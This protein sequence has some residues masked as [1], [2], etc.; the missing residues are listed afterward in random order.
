MKFQFELAGKVVMVTG[1]FSGLGLHFSRTLA[2]QGCTVAMC[3]RRIELGKT[4]AASIRELGEVAEA[5]E[6][7]V[8][9]AASVSRCLSAI[10]ERFGI[11][12]VLVNN[13]GVAHHAPALDTSDE[14]WSQT[15]DVNLTGVWRMTRAF[16]SQLSSE[17]KEGSVINIASI[18]GLRVAQQ[19]A[20]Y[21]VCKA[22]V[23]QMTKALALELARYRIRVNA[24]AP[25]Y[26]ETDLNREFFATDAGAQLIKRI[27]SRRLGRVEEL[28][29]PLLLLASGAS[30][31]MNGSVVAVDGGHLVSSL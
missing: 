9:D 12:E 23:V 11:A 29:G 5:F 19:V 10:S 31:F 30:S 6:L 13:A 7:D 17:G 8:T 18:L 15:L 2:S 1:A 4:V 14:S 21:A 20:A 25:G 22:G 26:F 3:G 16:A 27:P 24:I 28:D